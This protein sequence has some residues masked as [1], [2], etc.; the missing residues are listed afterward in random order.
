MERIPAGGDPLTLGPPPAAFPSFLPLL[1]A[2]GWF[3]PLLHS[4]ALCSSEYCIL[5]AFCCFR[6]GRYY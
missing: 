4:T 2:P 5:S 1:P 3:Q 6:P